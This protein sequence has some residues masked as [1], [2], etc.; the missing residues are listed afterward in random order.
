MF[1]ALSVPLSVCVCLC[2]EI[3]KFSVQFRFRLD[4]VQSGQA[5]RFVGRYL[6]SAICDCFTSLLPHSLSIAAGLLIV[7]GSPRTSFRHWD[8]LALSLSLALEP[9]YV[10]P[11]GHF[12]CLS[13]LFI[14]WSSLSFSSLLLSWKSLCLLLMLHA[15]NGRAESW[16]RELFVFWLNRCFSSISLRLFPFLSLFL[17]FFTPP[18]TLF[19]SSQHKN[20]QNSF[21]FGSLKSEILEHSLF[22]PSLSIC[23]LFSL[24]EKKKKIDF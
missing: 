17:L 5:H 7:T 19:S 14:F 2:V 10:L 23:R 8:V 21:L 4:I 1:V 18:I 12:R 11:T 22:W 9:F 3:W 6:L 16:G 20:V 24:E 13:N 15:Q